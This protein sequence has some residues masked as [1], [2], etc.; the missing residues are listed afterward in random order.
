MLRQSDAARAIFVTSGA[1]RNAKAF[2]SLY[3]AT[4]AALEAL[5]T[6]YA[7]ENRKFGIKANLVSP[8]PTRTAMRAKAYPGEDP[9]TLPTPEEI[10]P[11]FVDLALPSCERS[12]E[13]VEFRKT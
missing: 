11:L 12:G 6:S 2:W 1:A 9:M 7:A 10:A 13:I 5:V 8:G 3:S 4:K